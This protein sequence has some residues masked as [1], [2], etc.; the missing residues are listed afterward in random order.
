LIVPIPLHWSRRWSRG[1]DQASTIARGIAQVT[2]IR[3]ASALLRRRS[4]PQQRTE[5]ATGRWDNVRGAFKMKRRS[6]V[7]GERILLVDDVLTTGA[8]ADSA[9]QVL[10]H[11]GAAQVEVGILAHR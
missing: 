11:A 3:F 5:S 9:S 2:G 7:T 8:T 10:L 1:Y 4:T 6:R